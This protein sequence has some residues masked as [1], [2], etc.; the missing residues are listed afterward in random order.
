MFAHLNLR[1]LTLLALAVSVSL[2]AGWAAPAA[3]ATPAATVEVTALNL[4]AGP[5]F[6][7]LVLKVLARDQAVRLQGRSQD[8]VWAEVRL[9]D[10][11]GGWVFAGFLKTAADLSALPVTEA[12]G[13][14]TGAGTPGD[15]GYQVVLTITD[16]QAAL[17]VQRFPKNAAVVARLSRP[18][19][20]ASVTVAQGVTDSAGAVQL[21]FAMPAAWE[22]GQPLTETDLRLSVATVDG[23]YTRTAAIQYYR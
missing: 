23:R 20:G 1:R 3:A 8:G 6:R 11:S 16:Q 13:G 2:A 17:T 14:P 19:G 5:G 7:Y 22:N 9:A 21:G 15:A 18:D 4:R 10:G 12:A